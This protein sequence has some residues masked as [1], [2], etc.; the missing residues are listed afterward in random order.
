ML[1]ARAPPPALRFPA[2]GLGLAGRV[3]LGTA[4]IVTTVLAAALVV[5]TASLRRVDEAAARRRLEQDADLVAH[6]LA[7]RERSLAGGARVFVQGGQF[8]KIALNPRRE[9]ILDQTFEAADLL[10]ADWV[11]VT[12]A[13]GRVIAKS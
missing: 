12:D 2:R 1:G 8:R 5:T 11:F 13:R 9:D 3:F 7:G 10:G 4:V 6:L